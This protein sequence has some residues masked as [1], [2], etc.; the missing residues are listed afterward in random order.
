MCK[1]TRG[2]WERR[3]DTW[4]AQTKGEQRW[5]GGVQIFWEMGG[6]ICEGSHRYQR[7]HPIGGGPPCPRRAV[8]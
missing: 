3:M 5:D 2:E 1:D 4:R 8:G 7:S 6:K